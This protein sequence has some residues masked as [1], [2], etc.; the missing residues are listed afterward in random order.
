MNTSWQVA[1]FRGLTG[2]T[3]GMSGKEGRE[4]S[5]QPQGMLQTASACTALPALTVTCSELPQDPAVTM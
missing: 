3:A 5:G 1:W 2:D 4:W